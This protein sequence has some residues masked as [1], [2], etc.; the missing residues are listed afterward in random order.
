MIIMAKDLMLKQN[1][2]CEN[3]TINEIKPQ[4]L[5][6]FFPLYVGIK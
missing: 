3:L 5:L 6:L 2:T 4:V 1:G